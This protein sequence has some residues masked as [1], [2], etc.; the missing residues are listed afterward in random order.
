M[1][2]PGSAPSPAGGRQLSRSLLA[3]MRTL[4]SLGIFVAATTLTACDRQPQSTAEQTEFASWYAEE[5]KRQSERYAQQTE[6]AD[7][8]LERSAAQLDRNDVLLER[9]EAQ[10]DR[11]D[12]VLSAWESNIKENAR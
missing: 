6:E 7:K 3:S 10:A 11:L 5:T 2:T 1:Y 12:A 4:L 8:Q 9:Q